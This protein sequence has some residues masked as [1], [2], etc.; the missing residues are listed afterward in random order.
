MDRLFKKSAL[1]LLLASSIIFAGSQEEIFLRA[2]K[3]YKEQNY[4]QALE[5]YQS[6]NA[7]G[8]AVWENIGSCFYALGEYTHALIA[9]KR[10]EKS[11]LSAHCLAIHKKI[12]VVQ[13]AL[14]QSVKQNWWNYFYNYIRCVTSGIS[15]LFIQLLFLLVWFSFCL[16]VY[17]RALNK[18]YI[19]LSLI[20]GSSVII[21]GLI[22]II[23]YKKHFTLIGIV[24]PQ[25]ITLF[26]GPDDNFHQLGTLNTAQ[27]VV[28]QDERPNWYKINYNQLTGWVHADAIEKI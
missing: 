14:D 16:S 17:Y 15:L 8:T 1:I 9:F 2:N 23:Q 28:I 22:M 12:D 6:M 27:E 11:V 25:T 7:K 18:K 26:T 5:L 3:L 4:K 20:F 19:F 10:A 24:V 13:D 21:I